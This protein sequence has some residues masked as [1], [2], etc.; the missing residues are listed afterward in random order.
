M[1]SNAAPTAISLLFT[2]FAG[3]CSAAVNLGGIAGSWTGD[4]TCTIRDS[5]CHDEHVIYHLT[6]PDASGKL[7]IQADKV[8]DGKPVDM[9]TL[10]CTFDKTAVAITC[11]IPQ[12]T[13]NFTIAGK[14]MTGTLTHPDGRLFR[15][16]SVTKDE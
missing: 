14:K 1:R 11:K 9:G 7:Q 15:K 3:S 8:V 5:P 4:S 2:V 12:G 6:E 16:V 13:W 10:D